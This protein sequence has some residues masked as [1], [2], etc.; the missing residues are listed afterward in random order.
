MHI[1]NMQECKT[2]L[3][4]LL[5]L[6]LNSLAEVTKKELGSLHQAA[7]LARMLLS[8][9]GR[10]QEGG[11]RNAPHCESW[12]LLLRHLLWGQVL[13]HILLVFPRV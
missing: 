5:S 3:V 10:K 6:L 7:W 4:F 1:L 9:P 13:M 12:V 2:A 11:F 8:T